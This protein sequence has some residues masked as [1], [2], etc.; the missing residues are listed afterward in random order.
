MRKLDITGHLYGRLM[1][2]S[3]AP[4]KGRR[5][6][7]NCQCVCGARIVVGTV[8]LRT[9][10]TRS[11]GCFSKER[12]RETHKTHGLSGTKEYQQ[13]AGMLARCNDPN[14]VGYANYGGRGVVVCERW[15]H[16]TSFLEDMGPR[17]SSRHSIDRIDPNGHYEPGNCKWSTRNEQNNNQR[18]NRL[19]THN[20]R[21]Q[22]I[23]RW[24][25]EVGVPY[26]TFYQRVARK[27]IEH[28]VSLGRVN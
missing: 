5:T 16:Y 4:N 20:G 22:N 24:A 23:S 10:N 12:I 14:H 26:K 13:W 6:A 27:G 2:I 3:P 1:V 9:G 7:W 21:T 17:P 18:S 19:L 8:H 11:C 15:T 28:A 25:S